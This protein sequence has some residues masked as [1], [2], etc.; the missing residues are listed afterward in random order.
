MEGGEGP[1]SRGI[2]PAAL[3][4]VFGLIGES[5]ARAYLVRA[6]FLEIYNEEIRDLLS[7]SPRRKLG[8]REASDGSVVV[9]GLNSFVVKSAEEIFR[10]LEVGGSPRCESLIDDIVLSTCLQPTSGHR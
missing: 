9:K 1:G 3:S 7:K 6:S 2:I 4:H 10:V 8:L 5:E